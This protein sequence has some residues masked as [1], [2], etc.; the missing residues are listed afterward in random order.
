MRQKQVIPDAKK[1]I[2]LWIEVWDNLVGHTRNTKWI[3]VMSGRTCC[4]TQHV[5]SPRTFF[6]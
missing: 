5:T 3:I 2:K 4:V 6:F 1:K